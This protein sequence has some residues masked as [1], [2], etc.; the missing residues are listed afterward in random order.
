MC[1][2]A[3]TIPMS[4][5]LIILTVSYFIIATSPV[6]YTRSRAATATATAT[7]PAATAF[8][9]LVMLA[10]VAINMAL[11][12]CGDTA[13]SPIQETNTYGEFHQ[14]VTMIS[15]TC[16]Q[17]TRKM[18]SR[19]GKRTRHHDKTIAA[20]RKIYNVNV[21]QDIEI[22]LTCHVQLLS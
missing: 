3:A 15:T 5:V 20:K 17:T 2:D 9:G 11:A 19:L 4:A 18:R 10:D 1:G 12:V 7:A 21:R 6:D 22:T 8:E 14:S 13:A 16:L